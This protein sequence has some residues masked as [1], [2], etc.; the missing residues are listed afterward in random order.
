ADVLDGGTGLDLASFSDATAGVSVNLAN[1]A[2]NTGDAQ[3]DVYVSIEQL[4]G[5]DFAD[6]L[7]G[8]SGG[9]TIWAGAGDDLLQGG[10]GADALNGG[11]G[12]DTADYSAS[13][14]G[15]QI[16]LGS[17]SSGG[18][19][20]GDQLSGIENLAG[21]A[22]AD[23][24]TGDAGTNVLSGG[25]GNDVL[26]GAA[27]AD[28]LNGGTGTDTASYAGASAGVVVNLTNASTNTGDAKGDSYSSIENLTGSN[29]ADMLT[30]KSGANVLN[31]G[32]GKDMLTGAAGAD[33]LYGGAGADTFVFKTLSDSTVSSTGRDTIFDFSHAQ[34]DRI[35]L[36]SIDANTA[37]V[38][39]QSFI[40]KGTAEFSGAKGELRYD[41]QAS[42]TY[43]YGDVNGDKK[44]D[45]A[46]HLDD[47]VKFVASDF[48]L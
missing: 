5:S 2:A 6:S 43:V 26:S 33:D 45:F 23:M 48:L 44:A 9:N 47:A 25:A 27:G 3:G 8:D 1:T 28:T 11:D 24:L 21:S 37:K 32:L 22:F 31:G 15:V 7:T 4:G 42:D 46:I 17:L 14:A 34:G 30:G 40:F 35:K 10:A 16:I 41:K 39:D 19:A 20:A 29:F 38:G 18:D 12:W 13:L 36:S